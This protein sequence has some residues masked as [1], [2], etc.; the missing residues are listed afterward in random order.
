MNDVTS[1]IHRVDFFNA[2]L[3]VIGAVVRPGDGYRVSS[4]PGGR[5]YLVSAV[6][7]I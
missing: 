3:A 6:K 7:R 5:S 4:E 1:D 2:R